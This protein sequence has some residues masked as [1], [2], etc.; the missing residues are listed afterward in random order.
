MIMWE[1][2]RDHLALL[3]VRAW[4]TDLREVPY[5][6]VL[7]EAKGFQGESWTVQV[8]IIEQEM[9]GALLT[10]EEPVPVLHE[11]GQPLMFDFFGLGQQGMDPAQQGNIPVWGQNGGGQQVNHIEKGFDLNMEAVVE[12]DDEASTLARIDPA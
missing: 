12:G 7:T 5:F 4:V 3:M 9:L 1:N 11:N 2:D 6:L 10:D 8:E